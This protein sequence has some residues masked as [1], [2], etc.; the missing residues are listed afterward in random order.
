MNLRAGVCLVLVLSIPTVAGRTVQ[1]KRSLLATIPIFPLPDLVLFPTVSVPLRIF[2]PRYRA[3]VE[4]ALQSDRIIG[5]VTLKPGFEANYEGRPPI[6]PIGCAGVI[7][8]AER[9]PGGEFNLVVRGLVKVRV[10]GEDHTRSYRMAR[11]DELP[12]GPVGADEAPLRDERRRLHAILVSVLGAARTAS[13]FPASMSDEEFVNT[14]AQL[15]NVEVASQQ[16][17][18]ERPGVLARARALGDLV[19]RK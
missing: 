17:L 10:T 16:M 18:L 15:A 1:E 4:D 9:L 3:L 5:L 6:Y 11:V 13:E 2:E 12:E 19:S 7:T 14:L 8:S